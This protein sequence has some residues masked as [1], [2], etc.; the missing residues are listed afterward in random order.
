MEGKLYLI[1]APLGGDEIRD[2][3]PEGTIN[4]INSLS[5]FV[6][7]ELRSAR[8]YLSAA[9]FKGRID[10][11]EFNLLNEHTTQNIAEKYIEALKRGTSI[12]LISEAGLP[13]VADPGSILVELAHNND[14][15]VIP[16]TGPSSLMLALM[17]SGK[18]GQNFTFNGY[19]PVKR[20]ERRDKIRELERISKRMGI[21]QIFIETPYR[22]DSVFTDLLEVCSPDTKIT[23]ACNLT[24]SDEYIKTKTVVKW[25]ENIPLL[26]KRPTVFII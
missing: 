26:G 5:Y 17:A 18:N 9:G 3:I 24:L 14:I 15:E 1:P 12:G 23:V 7:E 6:V 2:V 25:R 8:R 4:I 20:E 19:L 21:S 10:S 13:A 22:N 16:L 11:L